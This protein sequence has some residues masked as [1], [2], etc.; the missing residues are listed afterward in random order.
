MRSVLLGHGEAK[1]WLVARSGLVVARITQ[2]LSAQWTLFLPGALQAMAS[3]TNKQVNYRAWK[4]HVSTRVK[5][6]WWRR[7]QRRNEAGLADW[8][9]LRIEE[10]TIFV[11]THG[12][13]KAA[14][15][16]ALNGSRVSNLTDRTGHV[17][18]GGCCIEHYWWG[19]AAINILLYTLYSLAYLA[20]HP[21]P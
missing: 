5:S 10:H 12:N 2:A 14:N 19:R 13:L 18:L 21:G 11:K 7:R 16:S 20:A 8:S 4:V 15:A 17:G 6:I 3:V 9:P 1:V